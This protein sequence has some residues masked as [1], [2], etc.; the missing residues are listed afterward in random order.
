MNSA[1]IVIGL[2]LTIFVVLETADII[3]G[4][5][6]EESNLVFVTILVSC[7]ILLLLNDV[8]VVKN[9]WAV[10]TLW[11]MIS[12]AAVMLLSLIAAVVVQCCNSRFKERWDSDSLIL[13]SSAALATTS[14][15]MF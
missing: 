3:L 6:Y 2:L 15:C 4:K 14:I 13:L 10:I 9:K 12:A 11:T 7:V 8:C 5:N 1:F